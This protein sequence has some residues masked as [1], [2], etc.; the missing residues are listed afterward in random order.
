MGTNVP[1]GGMNV[2]NDRLNAFV[3]VALERISKIDPTD[4]KYIQ[5]YLRGFEDALLL[6]AEANQRRAGKCSD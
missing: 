1:I 4:D 2:S 6:A 3:A 5:D